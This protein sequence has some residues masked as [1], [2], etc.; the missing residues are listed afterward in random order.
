MIP[1]GRTHHNNRVGNNWETENEVITWTIP[2]T[3]NLNPE[4]IN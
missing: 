2:L 3:Y 1:G 4:N